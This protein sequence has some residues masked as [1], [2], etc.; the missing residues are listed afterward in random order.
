MARAFILNGPGK[1]TLADISYTTFDYISI[2]SVYF[3]RGCY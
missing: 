1:D 2:F 3:Y